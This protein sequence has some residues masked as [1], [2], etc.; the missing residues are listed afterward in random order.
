MTVPKKITS[1]YAWVA[2]EANGGEGIPAVSMMMGNGEW[3]MPLFG[4]DMDRIKSLRGEAVRLK[5]ELGIRLRLC[6]FQ[7]ADELDEL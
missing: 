3:I 2:T 4:A 6:R 5:A 7:L 1:L